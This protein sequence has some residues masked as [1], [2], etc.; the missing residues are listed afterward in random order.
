M[1]DELLLFRVSVPCRGLVVFRVQFADTPFFSHKLDFSPVF[2]QLY[3]L[4]EN[5]RNTPFQ[6]T[7]YIPLPY[8]MF[9]L[10][11]FAPCWLSFR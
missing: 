9:N 1:V 4:G 8:I 7:S 11:D 10:L 2:S 3:P 5:F 6:R